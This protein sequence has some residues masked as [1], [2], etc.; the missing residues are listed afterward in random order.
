MGGGGG[1]TTFP[2]C[3]SMVIIPD[4]Q[5]QLTYGCHRYMQE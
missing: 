3:K 4:A 2:H 5:G 1:F